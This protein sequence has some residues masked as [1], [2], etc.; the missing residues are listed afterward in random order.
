MQSQIIGN[1]KCTGKGNKKAQP[2]QS[3]LEIRWDNVYIRH[4]H[5]SYISF[6]C[7]VCGTQTNIKYS[8]Y[9]AKQPS[10]LILPSKTDFYLM[11]GLDVERGRS[12]GG[13]DGADSSTTNESFKRWV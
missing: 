11:N 8:R 9:R 10:G 2:C 3:L 7:P 4:S 1:F 13:K 12:K 5:R 6:R